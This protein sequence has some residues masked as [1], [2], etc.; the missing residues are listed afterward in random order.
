[1]VKRIT[2]NGVHN[3]KKQNRKLSIVKGSGFGTII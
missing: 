3:V 2:N 1:M